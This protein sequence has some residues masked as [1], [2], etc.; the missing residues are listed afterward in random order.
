MI[1]LFKQRLHFVFGFLLILIAL[2]Q[3]ALAAQSEKSLKDAEFQKLQNELNSRYSKE[4][5]VG[6]FEKEGLSGLAP[7]DISLTL[8]SYSYR[9]T[10]DS[11][12]PQVFI[13][14]KCSI[15]ISRFEKEAE[16]LRKQLPPN[17][18]RMRIGLPDSSR[19]LIG[20]LDVEN[21]KLVT[22]ASPRPSIK[23]VV[24]FVKLHKD[25]PEN[26]LITG[27]QEDCDDCEPLMEMEIGIVGFDSKDKVYKFIFTAKTYEHVEADGHDGGIGYIDRSDI[28]WSDWINNEYRELIITTKREILRIEGDATGGFKNRREVY[29]WN[30]EKKLYLAE[31]VDD[32][33][34]IPVISI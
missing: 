26:I 32:G 25:S 13:I 27:E 11:G 33:R 6:R 18:P 19:T 2:S 7:E 12:K 5:V 21:H 9:Y 23:P 20:V 14:A 10:D 22:L 34:G 31:R 29:T 1:R 17:G 16:E 3:G 15:N 30:N 28:S 8:L 24:R 4:K